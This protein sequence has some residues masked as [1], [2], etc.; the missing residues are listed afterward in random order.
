M[1]VKGKQETFAPV[2]RRHIR[3]HGCRDLMRRGRDSRPIHTLNAEDG[4]AHRT[5]R[6]RPF[7]IANQCGLEIE[8]TPGLAWR[9]GRAVARSR[10]RLP[11]H[12]SF[13]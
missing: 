13:R 11:G 12:A 10:G 7:R 6:P 8:A 5:C 4:S 2:T 9:M 1:V 3:S